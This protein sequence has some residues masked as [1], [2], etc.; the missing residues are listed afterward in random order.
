MLQWGLGCF[1]ATVAAG[2]LGCSLE[3]SETGSN[4]IEIDGSSTVYPV[5][6]A[7]VEEY[8]KTH[9]DVTI[10]VSQTGT[11][12][13]FERFARGET[14]ISD[15]SRF[16]KP[17]EI[18]ACK[19]NG[20]DY[21]ELQIAIDGLTVVVNSEND[22]CDA[23]TVDQLKQIWQK[24]SDVKKWSDVDPSWPD[25]EIKMFGPGTESGTY[26]YFVEEICGKDIGSRSDYE[27]SSKDNVLVEGIA[28]E[29]YALG[30]FGYAYYAE[31]KDRLKALAISPTD[32]PEDGVLPT[33]ENVESGAYTP[34]SRPLFI[35][36][37]KDALK[38]PEVVEFV[39]FY[40]SKGQEFVKRVKYV[41]L[42][43]EILDEMNKRFEEAKS[44][45]SGSESKPAAEEPEQEKSDE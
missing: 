5:S 15:A 21:V 17:K 13:G 2:C 45:V 24:D 20:I 8:E 9:P 42:R 26:D 27:Y 18:K 36:V 10:T 34:L 3:E 35:Y 38:R 31:N 44:S 23:L 32:N 43:Q 28:G 37:R 40:L 11:G 14:V 22:W 1:L 41:P 16:I 19:E 6:F 33:T 29:K 4:Q 12:A 39:D 7:V 30:Y 25:E